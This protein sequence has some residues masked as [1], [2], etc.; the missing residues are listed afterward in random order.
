MQ[1][2]NE[3]NNLLNGNYFYLYLHIKKESDCHRFS[4]DSRAAPNISYRK[5]NL[6]VSIFTFN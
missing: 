6:N 2:S 4:W 5:L 3:T 1:T